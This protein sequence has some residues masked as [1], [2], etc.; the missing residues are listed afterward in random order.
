MDELNFFDWPSDLN[1]PDEWE[2]TS[3]AQDLTPSYEFNG[4][5]IHIDHPDPEKSALKMEYGT[6]EDGS[7]F[8][9]FCVFPAHEEEVLENM[10]DTDDFNEVIKFVSRKQS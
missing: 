7:A 6:K 3:W 9:R 1:I 2:N 8:H 10:L 4:W 5:K